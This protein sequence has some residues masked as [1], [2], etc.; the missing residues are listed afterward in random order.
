MS[1]HERWLQGI[2]WFVGILVALIV[3][4]QFIVPRLQANNA[5]SSSGSSGGGDVQS[6]SGQIANTS[7]NNKCITVT[8]QNGQSAIVTGDVTINGNPYFNGDP[9]TGNLDTIGSNESAN[10][11]GNYGFNVQTNIPNS[12]LQSVVTSDISDMEHK[13][14]CGSTCSNVMTHSL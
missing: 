10:I 6:P 1:N 7:Y 5:S 2:Y 9:S 3:I 11:C 8:T 4:Y 12:Q 13:S 14:G